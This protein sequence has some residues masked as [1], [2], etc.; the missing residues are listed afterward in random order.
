[1]GAV[2]DGPRHDAVGQRFGDIFQPGRDTARHR[3]A[4]L[5]DQQHGGAEHGFLA[6]A[7]RGSRAQIAAF[8]D[9][10]DIPDPDG[11]AAAR[12]DDDVP[13]LADIADLARRANQILLAVALDI[14]GADI[15]IVGGERRHD[16]AKAESVGHQLAGVGE[17]VELPLEAADGVDLDHAGHVA[18]LRLDDPVLH[19]AQIGQ[20]IVVT[21]L[22][23][24]ARLGL[25]GVHEDFAE[26]GRDRA[27]RDL[28][29][30]RK[31]VFHLLD[32]FADKLAGKIDV[33]AVLEDDRHLAQA[34]A[35]QRAGVVEFRQAAHRGLD[36]EGDALLGFQ[37][38]MAG[39]AGVDL[40]LDVGDVGYGVDRKALEIPGPE[41]D[42]A[43]REQQDQPALL[44][45]ERDE[46][47]NH[48]RPRPCPSPP[49]RRSCFPRRNARRLKGRP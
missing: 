30:G 49:S 31:L 36:G 4:V 23:L 48:A 13:D 43:E 40:D 41:G 6:I 39:R 26:S 46:T 20:R 15:G 2:V 29:A 11:I 22:R 35:R 37:R 17:H 10:R 16:V 25:D 47:L 12:A 1:M 32:A 8:G 3:A 34:V 19:G 18:K 38:R 28:D 27:H 45:R 42:G 14:A 7:G 5:A 24:R 33:G 44:Q 21:A 9:G